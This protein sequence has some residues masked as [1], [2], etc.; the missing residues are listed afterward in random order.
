MSVFSLD[1]SFL[2]FNWTSHVSLKNPTTYGLQRG[3]ITLPR[4]CCNHELFPLV[5]AFPGITRKSFTPPQQR[6]VAL[7]LTSPHLHPA[8]FPAVQALLQ[9][10]WEGL[11]EPKASMKA[12]IFA[13]LTSSQQLTVFHPVCLMDLIDTRSWHLLQSW[14][15]SMPALRA[16]NLPRSGFCLI[17]EHCQAAFFRSYVI[18]PFSPS[19]LYSL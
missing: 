19:F 18:V 6:G 13:V 3:S 16:D 7:T 4:T 10:Q 12:F 8:T 14:I 2:R 17:T 11:R 9:K 5:T 1:T 15:C